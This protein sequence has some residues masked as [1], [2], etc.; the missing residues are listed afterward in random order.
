MAVNRRVRDKANINTLTSGYIVVNRYSQVVWS[1]YLYSE[2]CCNSHMSMNFHQ[3]VAPDRY[4]A[5]ISLY[6]KMNDM[7][8]LYVSRLVYFECDILKT[9]LKIIYLNL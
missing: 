8:A 2:R 6:G 4:I 7:I 5:L 3:D 9:C 1:V